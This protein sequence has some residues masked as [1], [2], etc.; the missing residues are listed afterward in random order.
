[1]TVTL[2]Y[3]SAAFSRVKDKNR[4]RLGALQSAGRVDVRLETTVE[5]IDPGHVE[6]KSSRGGDRLPN[7]AIVVC[8]GGELPTAMLRQVGIEFATKHGTE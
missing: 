3:R 5:R 2:S 4:Q 6:L 7:D 1:M 8:A